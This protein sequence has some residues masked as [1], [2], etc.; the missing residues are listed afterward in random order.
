MW[1]LGSL[2]E[3]QSLNHSYKVGIYWWGREFLIST[4]TSLQMKA[5]KS[6]FHLCFPYWNLP[7][8][9]SVLCCR[10]VFASCAQWVT[11]SLSHLELHMLWSPCHHP[12]CRWRCRE[13]SVGVW[14]VPSPAVMIWGWKLPSMGSPHETGSLVAVGCDGW[15][16]E[17]L[18]ME[19]GSSTKPGCC[20]H[21]HAGLSVDLCSLV[22]DSPFGCPH[23]KCY[24][25][26]I[27]VQEETSSKWC[28]LGLCTGINTV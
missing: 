3:K 12:W 2:R 6:R 27:S 10:T 24:S 26:W 9:P 20:R 1:K 25:Q 11:P 18:L 4:W 28:L 16:C 21:S 5:K 8:F 13:C 14:L 22:W 17:D 19:N 7:S 15:A 23:P